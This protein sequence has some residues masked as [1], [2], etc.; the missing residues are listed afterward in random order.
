MFNLQK[1]IYTGILAFI[2]LMGV[3]SAQAALV[4]YTIT[5]DVIFGDE[6]FP[7]A[8]GLTAAETITATGVFDDSVLTSGSGTVLFN[9]GSGNS[10][11]LFVG[12]ET[13][14]ASNDDRYTSGFPSITMTNF[15][16]DD[17]DFLAVIG[18]NGAP[19]DFSS[20]F[21]GFD[22]FDALYG[23]WRTTVEISAVPVPAALWLFGSGLM[24]LVLA[25]RKNKI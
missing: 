23:E 16:L 4:N 6:D 21:N 12:S 15:S 5:G 8:F 19:A 10:M 14:T 18:S 7:N 17:F 24:A 3:N 2:M 1:T 25:G 9:S 20:F 13:F 11:T 22:D